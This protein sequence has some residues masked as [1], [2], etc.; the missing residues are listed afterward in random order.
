MRDGECSSRKKR[1]ERYSFFGLFLRRPEL[2]EWAAGDVSAS[3]AEETSFYLCPREVVRI[4]LHHESRRGFSPQVCGAW[5]AFE[6]M[7]L[8]DFTPTSDIA[9]DCPRYR[10]SCARI[11]EKWRIAAQIPP[12]GLVQHASL[13]DAASDGD[14]PFEDAVAML[15]TMPDSFCKT[16]LQNWAAVALF[17]QPKAIE[18]LRCG[19]EMLVFQFRVGIG[20]SEVDDHSM[21]LRCQRCGIWSMEDNGFVGARI[22]NDDPRRM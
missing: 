2:G 15:E 12:G 6:C 10:S 20:T 11:L 7:S 1:T 9:S 17:C 22:S 4:Y 13:I 5:S 8:M 21:T 3:I 16:Y 14:L 19:G 18:C